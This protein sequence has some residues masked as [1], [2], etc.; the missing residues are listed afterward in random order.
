MARSNCNSSSCN[1][2]HD[3]PDHAE[4]DQRDPVIFR[5]ENIPGMRI[6]V[7]KAVDQNLLEVSAE[8]FFGEGG[9]IEFHPGERTQIGDFFPV[10]VFHRQDA[11]RAVVGDRQRGR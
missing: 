9:A 5:Q 3:A 11:R 7:K 2:R 1:P 10:H 6:G 4:I 8:K